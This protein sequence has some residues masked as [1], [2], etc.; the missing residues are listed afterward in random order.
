MN[1]VQYVEDRKRCGHCKVYVGTIA[2]ADRISTYEHDILCPN[3][4][5]AHDPEGLRAWITKDR[6]QRRELWRK[7]SAFRQTLRGHVTALQGKVAVLRHENNKL[8]AK[9]NRAVDTGLA[10]RGSEQ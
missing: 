10:G 3:S 1:K 5:L 4:P 9:I 2:Y 6:E 8:R 7:E